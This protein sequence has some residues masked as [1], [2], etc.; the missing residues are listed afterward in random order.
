[1]SGIG[2]SSQRPE[3]D[4]E[5]GTST[6]TDAATETPVPPPPSSA[7]SRAGRLSFA[8]MA[9]SL[10]P[11]VVIVLVVVGWQYFKEGSPNPVHEIDPSGTVRVAA[12]QASYDI[13]VPTGLPSGYRPTSADTDAG[14]KKKGEPV[15]LQIGYVTPAGAF[16]AFAESDDPHADALTAVLADAT[17]RGTVDI[18]GQ[19]WSR[20]SYEHEGTHTTEAALSRQVGGVT[21]LVNGSAREAELEQLADAVR[22][23]SG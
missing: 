1:M 16:A 9:R 4:P 22:P 17:S 11:L 12:T 5:G 6:A 10:L 8:N 20:W 2:P 19:T 23:Y 21:L 15:T 18:G 13:Q 7:Q 3:H 14:G